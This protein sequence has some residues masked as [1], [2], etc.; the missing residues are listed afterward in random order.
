[1]L[2]YI[3]ILLYDGYFSQFVIMWCHVISNL[4]LSYPIIW[5]TISSSSFPIPLTSFPFCYPISFSFAPSFSLSFPF[6]FTYPL[7]SLQSKVWSFYPRSCRWPIDHYSLV[8]FT[9]LPITTIL[10]FT[11][12]YFTSY[13]YYTLLYFL[14]VLYFTLF[15]FTL[16]T[17][18]K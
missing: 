13:Y 5:F 15:H 17:H 4:I 16:L 10:H 18:F 14:L 6:S 2:Y 8:H 1:M 12:L 11:L 7:T 3:I 9:L